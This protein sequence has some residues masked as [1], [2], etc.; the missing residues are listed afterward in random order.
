MQASSAASVAPEAAT[1]LLHA[2]AIG[3]LPVVVPS[4]LGQASAH[5]NAHATHAEQPADFFG[6]F[7]VADR[8]QDHSVNDT[9]E[10]HQS[11]AH[12]LQL[13]RSLLSAFDRNTPAA[14]RR[15]AMD[16]C[17]VS[18]QRAPHVLGECLLSPSTDL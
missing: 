15:L 13:F 11:H 16:S 12:A 4:P 8:H 5:P 6:S 1:G 9:P 17:R 10:I 7:P 14:G 2:P 18:P 3:K